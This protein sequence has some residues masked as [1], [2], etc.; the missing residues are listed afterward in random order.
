MK[1]RIQLVSVIAVAFLAMPMVVPTAVCAGSGEVAPDL[2]SFRICRE[3]LART[4]AFAGSG[5][6][7]FKPDR[8]RL[9]SRGEKMELWGAWSAMLDY[10][11]G[12]DGVAAGNSGFMGYVSGTLKRSSFTLVNASFLAEYRYAMEFI[13]LAERNPALE[14]ILDEPVPEFGI[15]GGSYGRYKFRF[16]NVVR[17]TEFAALQVVEKGLPGSDDPSLREDMREDAAAILRMARWK[18]PAL[19]FANA[20]SIVGKIGFSA[21]FPVQKGTSEF[22]GNVKLR[23]V[24]KSFITP[25]QIRSLP[26]RLVPGDILLERREWYLSN[27]GLP[28]FWT[29]A[30]LYVGTPEERRAFFNAPEIRQWVIERGEGS[31]DFE[32]LLRNRYPAAYASSIRAVEHDHLPRVLEAVSEGVVFT[33]LEHS[34]AADSLAVLRPRL[35]RADKAKAILRAFHYSGRPY[36]FNFDFRTDSTLVCSE[37]VYK[38][39]EPGPG[40]QGVRFPLAEVLG[41]PVSTPNDMARQFSEQYDTEARQTDFVLF[42]DGSEATDSA[43]ESGLSEFRQSWQRPK[44]HI[45]ARKSQDR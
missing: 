3:G 11:A 7:M 16:L 31:G 37:L 1:T 6:D 40:M 32:T 18:G 34:A 9:P 43:A 39:Y 19:T 20:L 30:A 22:M 36:D 41:R 12:L 45:M 38:V 33:T 8:K 28:G 13:A 2:L 4:V 17:A 14:T 21:W 35:S 26:S 15:A 10:T 42:L 23:H 24:G 25:E 5:K 44:W 27:L 29:H